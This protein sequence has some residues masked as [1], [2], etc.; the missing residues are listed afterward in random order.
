MA[1]ITASSDRSWS[2]KDRRS[3]LLT[4][5]PRV[6][7]SGGEVEKV[8]IV[9]S[10]ALLRYEVGLTAVTSAWN[11]S[12]LCATSKTL[13]CSRSEAARGSASTSE[14]TVVAS[15]IRSAS[16]KSRRCKLRMLLRKVRLCVVYEYPTLWC[17]EDQP[18]LQDRTLR[19]PPD[20]EAMSWQSLMMGVTVCSL[21]KT[22]KS[23]PSSPRCGRYQATKV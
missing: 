5:A 13:T 14:S 17:R 4:F 15:G 19:S 9:I 10:L 18:E 21:D 3:W 16:G 6:M 11:A 8:C 1:A 2:S 23:S 12:P 7:G 20:K 22:A